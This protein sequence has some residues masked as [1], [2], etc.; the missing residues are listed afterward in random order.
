MNYN[1][2]ISIHDR[3]KFF[4]GS[5]LASKRDDRNVSKLWQKARADNRQ[6]EVTTEQLHKVVREVGKQ[7]RRIVG[8]FLPAA[9]PLQ[10]VIP[11]A[12]Y[13]A[14]PGA[15]AVNDSG[16]GY[17]SG[18]V[19]TLSGGT[20]ESGGTATTI[21]VDTVGG[22]GAI[23]VSHILVSGQYTV[24]P[25]FPNAVTGGSGMGA[26]LTITS[27]ADTFK[28]F[29]MRSG[30]ISLRSRF[31]GIEDP[32]NSYQSPSLYVIGALNA[33]FQVGNYT[34]IFS[35]SGD[36]DYS[37]N[38][39]DDVSA[40]NPIVI[41]KIGD[42]DTLIVGFKASG[43]FV[44]YNSI[45]LD[46]KQDGDSYQCAV[47]LEVIDDPTKPGGIATGGVFQYVNLKAKMY[48]LSASNPFPRTNAGNTNVNIIPLAIIHVSSSRKVPYDIAQF[49][50]GNITSAFDSYFN[51]GGIPSDAS[52]G[53]AAGAIS[54][55]RGDWDGDS[56]N[57]Q[58]FFPG[59]WVT[60]G[61]VSTATVGG[62][63]LK[64][65]YVC[66]KYGQCKASNNTDP[67]NNSGGNWLC[68]TQ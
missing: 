56:L 32:G 1:A 28:S 20:L 10:S 53:L 68:T 29:A 6:R 5:K 23:L 7:K 21:F 31:F 19:L 2:A 8:G 16:E 60:Q 45:I 9:D 63:N 27:A 62:I 54:C 57:S 30:L 47:W 46:A 15:V 34:R 59:D 51:N 17:A 22:A 61:T 64:V 58:Y 37:L 39:P 3:P 42:P 4:A 25:T 44:T 26:K 65:K 40:Y 49:Q 36:N 18:N 50:T 14:T 52:S 38:P 66:I 24:Q 33:D 55:Y 48:D 11:F 12:F 43:E 41:G 35:I 67:V 13:N